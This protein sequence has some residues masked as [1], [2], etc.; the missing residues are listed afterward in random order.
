M[1]RGS[2]REQQARD[3]YCWTVQQAMDIPITYEESTTRLLIRAIYYILVSH[4]IVDSNLIDYV[5]HR[6]DGLV[7]EGGGNVADD[8][9]SKQKMVEGRFWLAD[10]HWRVSS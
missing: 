8:L 4:L 9:P 3:S 10:T 2:E 5:S 6:L 1:K 7:A